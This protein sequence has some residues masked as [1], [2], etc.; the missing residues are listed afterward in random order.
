MAK[1]NNDNP[2]AVATPIR[3]NA[4]VRSMPHCHVRF[5]RSQGCLERSLAIL[6]RNPG[7]T[8]YASFLTIARL[9]NMLRRS[10]STC[11][12]GKASPQFYAGSRARQAGAF[13][14]T[15]L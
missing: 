11:F 14:F 4:M 5:P 15:S 2:N 7:A 9:K 10:R 8:D 1:T 3:K 13:D 12:W 6:E